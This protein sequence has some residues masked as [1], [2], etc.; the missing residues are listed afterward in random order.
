MTPE[1]L[2]QGYGS[3]SASGVTAQILDR[4]LISFRIGDPAGAH[5]IFDA[6]GSSLASGRWNTPGSPLIYSSEHYSTALLE[7]LIRGAG[8]LLPNQHYIEIMSHLQARLRLC[9]ERPQSPSASPDP[10]AGF[11]ETWRSVAPQRGAS[12][13]I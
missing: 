10:A 12:C 5:R 3:A 7:K 11:A 13:W 9:S 6:T 4:T 2:L 8:R 1:Q